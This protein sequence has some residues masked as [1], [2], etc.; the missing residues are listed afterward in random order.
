M[1]LPDHRW[2]KEDYDFDVGADLGTTQ[3]RFESN[4]K[5]QAPLNRFIVL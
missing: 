1:I 2:R 3:E 5:T 4:C